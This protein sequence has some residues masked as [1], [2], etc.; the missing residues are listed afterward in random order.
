MIRKQFF[1]GNF[2]LISNTDKVG[3]RNLVFAVCFFCIGFALA[4]RAEACG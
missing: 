3:M 4:P 1:D 2:H